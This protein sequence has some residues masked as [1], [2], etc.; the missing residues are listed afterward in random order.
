MPAHAPTS[1]S[2]VS[3]MARFVGLDLHK[4]FIEVCVIDARGKIVYRGRTGCL[5]HELEQFGRSHL[6]R[7]D[8]A[9]LEATTNTW[10]VVDVLRPFVAEVVVG[11]PLKTKAIAEAKV[12]TD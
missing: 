5:R 6:R 3:T 7:T 9:A 12:K 1:T 4:R 11:N 8:R 2:E 10:A